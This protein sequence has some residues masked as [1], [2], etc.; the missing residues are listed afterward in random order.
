MA[1]TKMGRLAFLNTN[2]H[3][4][5]AL[6]VSPTHCK[7]RSRAES[8]SFLLLDRELLDGEM[9]D[10]LSAA[11]LSRLLGH[12]TEEPAVTTVVGRARPPARS[13]VQS[14]GLG[15]PGLKF[16]LAHTL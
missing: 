1:G 16:Y 4:T 3:G 7:C 2:L 15:L 11:G 6:T 8:F 13:K 14:F 9:R 5:R 12:E 10:R